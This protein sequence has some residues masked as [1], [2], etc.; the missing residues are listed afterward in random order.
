MSYKPEVRNVSQENPL[1]L[2]ELKKD[3]VRV[4]KFRF[5]E[6]DGLLTRIKSKKDLHK[7]FNSEKTIKNY[8]SKNKLSHKNEDDIA[9]VVAYSLDAN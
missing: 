4:T 2:G 5:I 1:M 7:F 9:K 8:I 3:L 6:K